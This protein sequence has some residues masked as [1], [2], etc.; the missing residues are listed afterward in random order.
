[1]SRI[2]IIDTGASNIKSIF[3]AINYLGYN[4]EIV[5]KSNQLVDTQCIILPGVGSFDKVM[6][7]IKAYNLINPLKKA[8]IQEKI[9]ILGICIGMQILFNKSEEG[10]ECGLNFINGTI[11]KLP[12]IIS[13][14]NKVPNTGFREVLFDTKN[15]LLTKDIKKGYLYFNHSYGLMS[16]SFSHKHD[17]STHNKTFVASFNYKNI[18]GMQFHPEKSQIFG[19]Y[20]LKNFIDLSYGN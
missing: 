2:K 12:Y 20:L 3:N 15:P 1:M 18:F 14:F 13:S 19:L 11:K 8:V 4:A 17:R 6:Q 7:S 5:R 10:K 9:P 16:E